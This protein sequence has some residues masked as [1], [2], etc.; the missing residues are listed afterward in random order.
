MGKIEKV[1]ETKEVQW[2]C[3]IF[4][5]QLQHAFEKMGLDKKVAKKKETGLVM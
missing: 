4:R 5:N 1:K 2:Q 3:S